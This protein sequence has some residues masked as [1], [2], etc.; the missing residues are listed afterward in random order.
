MQG[1]VRAGREPCGLPKP[2]TGFYRGPPSRAFQRVSEG[3]GTCCISRI[4]F[5]SQLVDRLLPL[6]V[7]SHINMMRHEPGATTSVPAVLFA[8]KG[9]ARGSI[10][11]SCRTL[12]AQQTSSR[13]PRADGSLPRRKVAMGLR[14][15]LALPFSLRIRRPLPGLCRAPESDAAGPGRRDR[16]VWPRSRT[17]GSSRFRDW[18]LPR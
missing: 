9:D 6:K 15:S 7:C 1:V 11:G 5:P 16:H 18:D 4:V 17:P 13:S 3:N 2:S 12:D 8:A 14:T 10:L